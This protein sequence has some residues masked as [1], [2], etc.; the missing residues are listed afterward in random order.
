MDPEEVGKQRAQARLGFKPAA[1]KCL[2]VAE[3][4]PLESD[5]FFYFLEV[6]KADYLFTGLMKALYSTELDYQDVFKVGNKITTKRLRLQK[7]EL[8]MLFERDGFFLIDVSDEPIPEGVVKAKRK[9]ILE[10]NLPGLIDK[11][12][13]LGVGRAPV[14]LIKKSVFDV[15]RRPMMERGFNVINDE[16]IPFPSYGHQGEFHVEM[17]KALGKSGWGKITTIQNRAELSKEDKTW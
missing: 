2:L 13:A 17:K 6:N 16:T 7:E 5:R 4:P 3:A 11:M 14:I 1:V 12:I 8:L 15:C 10:S 9:R